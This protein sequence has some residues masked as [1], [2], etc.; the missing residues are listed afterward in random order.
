MSLV[1]YTWVPSVYLYIICPSQ[2]VTSWLLDCV[3]V[4]TG[5]DV[6]T[7][8]SGYDLSKRAMHQAYYVLLYHSVELRT[9]KPHK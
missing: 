8:A 6:C 3:G 7:S 2:L 1:L 4:A 9:Q 5:E